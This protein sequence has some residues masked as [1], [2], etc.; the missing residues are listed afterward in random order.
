[1]LNAMNGTG[2]DA[3]NVHDIR[4]E[5]EVAARRRTLSTVTSATSP[6]A[7]MKAEVAVDADAAL[8]AMGISNTFTY[9]VGSNNDVTKAT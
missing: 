3:E 5:V 1:M 2:V 6:L 9:C 7:E 4:R 8:I